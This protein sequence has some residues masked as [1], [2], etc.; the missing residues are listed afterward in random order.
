MRFEGCQTCHEPHGSANPRMLTGD[1]R[2]VSSVS[3]VMRTSQLSRHEWEWEE[4]WAAFRP[5]F[6]TFDRRGFKT[7]QSV[8]KKFTAVT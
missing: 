6:M 7:A 3:S 2:S 5:H 1:M 4:P 8:I